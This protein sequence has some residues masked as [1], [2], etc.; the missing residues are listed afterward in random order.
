MLIIALQPAQVIFNNISPL[1][2]SHFPPAEDSIADRRGEWG[3]CD[4]EGVGHS[5]TGEVQQPAAHV[6]QWITGCIC[7]L[8]HH[9]LCESNEAKLV[10]HQMVYLRYQYISATRFAFP[11]SQKNDVNLFFQHNQVC[12]DSAIEPKSD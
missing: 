4:T 7:S 5:W 11:K 1:L 6:L 9:P 10:S 8:R 2:S 12:F 3:E